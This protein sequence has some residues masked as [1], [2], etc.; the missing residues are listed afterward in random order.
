MELA[1]FF[2]PFRPDGTVISW[3]GDIMARWHRVLYSILSRVSGNPSDI[4]PSIR[5]YPPFTFGR[6]QGLSAFFQLEWPVL[7]TLWNPTD[8]IPWI[9]HPLTATPNSHPLHGRLRLSRFARSLRRTPDQDTVS[10]TQLK[11]SNVGGA[12]RQICMK[13]QSPTCDVS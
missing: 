6:V 12:E 4:S 3:H 8:N 11:G 5:H 13:N 9:G 7:A 10:G 2:V 1:V